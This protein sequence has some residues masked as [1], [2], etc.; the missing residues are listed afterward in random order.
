MNKLVPI[1]VVALVAGGLAGWIFGRGTTTV[2]ETVV[3][4]I[5]GPVINS[6]FLTVNGVETHYRSQ[7]FATAST[8]RCALQ[9]P[10]HASSTLSFDSMLRS[11][12]STNYTLA[13]GKAATRFATPTSIFSEAITDDGQVVRAVASTTY[14]AAAFTDRQFGP[15]QWLIVT[16]GGTATAMDSGACSAIFS[17]GGVK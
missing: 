14:S 3:G 11:A 12:S 17:V 7:I 4:A 1:I 8:T 10:T 13:A 5:S 2:R 9:S 16:A 6:D 15:G